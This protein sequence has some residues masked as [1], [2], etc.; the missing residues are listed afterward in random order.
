MLTLSEKEVE[1]IAALLLKGMICFYQID[2]KKIHHMPDDED[3]F[4]YDLTPEEEDVLDEIDEN[5]D[6][7]AEFTKMEAN[8]EHQVM[9]IFTDREVKE[10]SF[11]D[12]LFNALSKP[13][14]ATGFKFLIDNSGKYNEKWKAYRLSKYKDWVKEQIDSFNYAEE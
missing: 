10:R 4:N 8:Q 12:E 7:Y 1:N 13:K 14:A 2:N 6:N 9:E 11:Q 5:P 3:Y